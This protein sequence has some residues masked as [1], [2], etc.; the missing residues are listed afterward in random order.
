MRRRLKLTPFAKLFI[1][2]LIVFAAWY[3]YKHKDEIN[4]KKIFN[5]NDSTIVINPVDTLKSAN[6]IEYDTLTFYVPKNDS[7]FRIF[8]NDNEIKLRKQDTSVQN[9]LFFEISKEKKIIGK[10]ITR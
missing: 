9:E 8:I 3:L 4:E 1:A 10:I 7:I 6:K 5:F 2:A